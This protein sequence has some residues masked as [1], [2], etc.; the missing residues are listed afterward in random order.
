MRVAFQI[1][2]DGNGGLLAICQV[3]GLRLAVLF[4]K[5]QLEFQGAFLTAGKYPCKASACIAG[6]LDIV[7]QT[8]GKKG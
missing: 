2:Q 8:I 7:F 4:P 6:I 3:Y 1:A 5:A